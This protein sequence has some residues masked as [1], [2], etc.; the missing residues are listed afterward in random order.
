VKPCK[1]SLKRKVKNEHDKRSQFQVPRVRRE[2]GSRKTKG[3]QMTQL[4]PNILKCMSAADRERYYAENGGRA[5]VEA[6]AAFAG[7]A[8]PGK[9]RGPNATE[10]G[11]NATERAFLKWFR[12]RSAE[13]FRFEAI[14]F[15]LPGGS[16]YTPDFIHERDGICFCFEVKGSYKLPSHGRALTAFREARANFN[17]FSFQWFEQ[18]EDGSFMEKYRKRDR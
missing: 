3:E 2:D 15:K 8:K 6:W 5:P 17:S 16:R 11:P 4:T 1:Q 18:Q 14:T 9:K 13:N 7:K 12:V 10:R